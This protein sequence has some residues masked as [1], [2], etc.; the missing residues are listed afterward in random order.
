MDA[1]L[2]VLGADQVLNISAMLGKPHPQ[3]GMA[4]D[5][6]LQFCTSSR[7]LVTQSMTYNTE[8]LCWELRFMGDEDLLTFR[9]GRLV[10]DRDELLLPPTDWRNLV[11]QNSQMLAALRDQQLGDYDVDGVLPAMR[12]L[13]QA[14]AFTEESL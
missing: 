6:S 9:N 2:W 12:L 1:A 3:F 11:A 8:Q 5:V 13:H 7:Q 14:E 4:M 10:N